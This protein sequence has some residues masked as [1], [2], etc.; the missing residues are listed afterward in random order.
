MRFHSEN[1]LVV[2]RISTVVYLRGKIDRQSFK[3]QDGNWVFA[4]LF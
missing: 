4:S 1:G 2:L 3:R